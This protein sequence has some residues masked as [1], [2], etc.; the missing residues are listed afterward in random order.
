MK[1][2]ICD[3]AAEIDG[4]SA[5][6]CIISTAF[7]EADGYTMPFSKEILSDAFFAIE[8]HAERVADELQEL[9]IQIRANA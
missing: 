8:C 5:L 2:D 4:I 9:D 6:A 3:L 1:R 7:S